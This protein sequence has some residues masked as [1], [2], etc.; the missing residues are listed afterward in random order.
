MD[1]DK[2][3]ER[4]QRGYDAIVHGL[5][6]HASSA[7]AAIDAAYARGENDEFVTPTVIDGVEGR[8]RDG[9]RSF[10]PTSGPT[11]PVS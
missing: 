11:E 6:E 10:T 8:V 4:T 3:W 2:R 5:G 1:R 7:M 9:D